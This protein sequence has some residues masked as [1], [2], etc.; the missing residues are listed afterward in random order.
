MQSK[1]YICVSLVP[2]WLNTYRIYFNKYSPGLCRNTFKDIVLILVFMLPF[3]FPYFLFVHIEHVGLNS[4]YGSKAIKKYGEHI[5]RNKKN[6]SN[7]DNKGFP[8]KD[9]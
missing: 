5:L 1:N 9:I 8:R 7:Q 6:T 3:P 4:S 2:P